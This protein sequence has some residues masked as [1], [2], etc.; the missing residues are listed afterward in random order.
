MGRMQRSGGFPDICATPTCHDVTH[1]T[2]LPNLLLMPLEQSKSPNGIT[3]IAISPSFHLI[4]EM[5]IT[6]MVAQEVLVCTMVAA[7]SLDARTI[8]RQRIQTLTEC[9][10][11]RWQNLIENCKLKIANFAVSCSGAIVLQ[12]RRAKRLHSINLAIAIWQL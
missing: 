12:A 8:N 5:E 3:S 4:G 2:Y 1:P 6:S 10:V 11:A 7:V 9:K